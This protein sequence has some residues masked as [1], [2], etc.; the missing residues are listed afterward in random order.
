MTFVNEHISKE[1]VEK[2]SLESIDKK[3][4][5]GGTNSRSWT[6]DRERDVYL[7]NLTRG[8]EENRSES[9][10][11]L[12]WHGEWIYLELSVVGADGKPGGA[13]WTHWKLRTIELPEQ[14]KSKRAEIL[15]DLKDA[16]IVYK[17]FGIYSVCT[18]YTVTL[19]V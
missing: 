19:D 17:D 9:G 2:Y 16:L 14:L 11:S 12:F 18:D 10:W 8:R 1:D 3:F 13:G 7:R 4:I 15:A 5:V 6:I